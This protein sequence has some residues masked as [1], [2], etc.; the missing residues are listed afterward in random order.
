VVED[1]AD[2]VYE[3]RD[4]TDLRPTGTKPWWLELPAAGRETW[5]ERAARRKRRESFRLAFVSS[6]YRIGEEPDPFILEVG[7]TTEPW[8]LR[9]V[10]A[11]VDAAGRAAVETA[12]AERRQRLETVALALAV[13]VEEAVRAGKPWTTTE[14][15]EFL[16]GSHNIKRKAA[17]QLI[18]DRTGSLWRVVPDR[19]RR[20]HP[21]LLFPA[22]EAGA[23][24]TVATAAE[25]IGAKRP[26]T[27]GLSYAGRPG[28]GRRETQIEIPAPDAAVPVG[29]VLRRPEYSLLS[30]CGGAD[31][32]ERPGCPAHGADE[33][34]PML[35]DPVPN[36]GGRR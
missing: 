31:S 24:Q 19:T 5:G 22:V 29:G 4:A 27:D 18:A 20:G 10:T 6:K 16:T 15:E 23:G 26:A 14:S 17:R 34:W 30:S 32:C 36:H 7:L 35:S 2:I 21:S 1:R 28:S 3:V 9:D 11:E 33:S 12:E 25:D 8:A 13:K